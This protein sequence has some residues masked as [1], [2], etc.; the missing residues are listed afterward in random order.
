VPSTSA[1]GAYR[2]RA[3][4]RRQ[5]RVRV[6]LTPAEWDT[7]TAAAARAGMAPGAY[8]AQALLDVAERR[9]VNL[10]QLRREMVVALMQAAAHVGRVGTS[11]DEAVAQLKA[12]GTPGPEL[13][14]AARHCTRVLHLVDDAAELVRRRPL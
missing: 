7:V 5:P 4:Q 6:W 10:S 2:T 14:H 9:T 3:G 8:A 13:E 1:R 11:L 12:S